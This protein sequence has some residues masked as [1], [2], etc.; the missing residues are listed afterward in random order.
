MD[1]LS[2]RAVV[3]LNIIQLGAESRCCRDTGLLESETALKFVPSSLEKEGG[4]PAERFH[5]AL[6]LRIRQC[7]SEG[8]AVLQALHSK[9]LPQD[10]EESEIFPIASGKEL[11]K[12]ITRMLLYEW[13]GSRSVMLRLRLRERRMPSTCG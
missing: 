8:A 12:C 5:D 4:L 2:A 1:K 13:V 7:R 3:C 11:D 9:L 6:T 10:E